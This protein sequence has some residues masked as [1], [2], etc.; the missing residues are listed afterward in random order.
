MKSNSQDT[1]IQT[2]LKQSLKSFMNK[3][4]A[5][6]KEAI[7]RMYV[8]NSIVNQFGADKFKEIHRSK[9]CER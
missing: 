1:L 2:A 7:P 3:V 5:K 6:K 9:S 8:S 4:P